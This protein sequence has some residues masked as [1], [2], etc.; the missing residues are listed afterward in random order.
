M[1]TIITLGEFMDCHDLTCAAL[2][3]SVGAS[4]TTVSRWRSGEMYPRRPHIEKLSKV[5]GMRVLV[6][7]DRGV[8][9][10]PPAVEAAE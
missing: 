3:E 8:L 2:G 9:L 5:T 4:G 7:S 1:S 10:Q 6:T